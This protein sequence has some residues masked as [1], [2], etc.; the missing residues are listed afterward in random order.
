MRAITKTTGTHLPMARLRSRRPVGRMVM[1]AAVLALGFM[2]APRADA[3]SGGITLILDCAIR[4]DKGG[5]TAWWGYSNI[6]PDVVVLL[7]GFDGPNFF[8]PL[9]LLR[10]QPAE[11]LPGLHPFVFSTTGDVEDITWHVLTVSAT[12]GVSP[13]QPL[14]AL[15]CVREVA[16]EPATGPASRPGQ[17]VTAFVDCPPR[18]VAFWGGASITT[19][20]P[21][22]VAVLSTVVQTA[23]EDPFGEIRAGWAA[24]ASVVDGRKNATVTI[25]PAATCVHEPYVNSHLGPPP[26]P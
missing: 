14:G 19:S 22:T 5:I 13:T 6:N 4:N 9:P 25:T 1:M 23:T 26:V 12:T 15:G 24:T 16:G 21:K 2:I 18:F 3:Q 10:G 11:F 17:T 20:D 8:T 7:P